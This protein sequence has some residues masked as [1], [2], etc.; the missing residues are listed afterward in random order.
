MIGLVKDKDD[1]SIDTAVSV[2]SKQIIKEV[3][4]V[5]IDKSKYETRLTEKELTE[6]TS[7]TL[8]LLLGQL[9]IKLNNT[10]PAYMIG[11]VVTGCLRNFSTTLQIALGVLVR[12][13]KA[14]VTKLHDF[15]I[16]C[17][18]D[19]VR[20]FKKSAAVAATE[21][22]N[23]TGISESSPSMIQTIVDNFDAD[24][25]SQN[26][27]LSTHFLAILMTQTADVET[28]PKQT[29]ETI[30]RIQHSEMTEAIDYTV[31]IEHYR[32]PKKPEMPIE[33]AKKAVPSLKFLASMEISLTRA[34]ETDFAFLQDVSMLDSCPEFN[35]CNTRHCR[36][37]GQYINSKTNADYLPLIDMTPS[38]PDTIMTAMC[39]AQAISGKYGQEF[40]V[41][42]GDLQLNRVA[43]N[44]IWAYPEQF[45]NVILRL[46]GM[47]FLMSFV[48][49]VGTLMAESGLSEI[50]E[51]TFGGVS[52]ML[53]GKKFPQNMRALR[54]VV[55][56]LLRPLFEAENMNCFRDLES[57]LEDIARE[58]RTAKSD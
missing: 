19:E 15:G 39:K 2:V 50:M 14:L 6:P 49:S 24:I 42:T 29:G 27:K 1:E 44:I 18:Y 38:D 46:G 21:S 43:V 17:S 52:K 37:A 28:S 54:L 56:E 57:I 12:N 34:Q 48:G 3:K 51:S 36:E 35:G 26:G 8:M 58:S 53:T 10:N 45:D 30:K 33:R 4:S 22:T 13:S 7:D 5:D 16:T 9:S 25:S 32:G 41:F 23:L 40:T 47:H 11:N 55:E 31:D 20:Q